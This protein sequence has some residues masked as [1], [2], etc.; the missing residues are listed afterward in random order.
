M[1]LPVV[2]GNDL[3]YAIVSFET[4]IIKPFLSGKTLAFFAFL[5]KTGSRENSEAGSCNH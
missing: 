3:Q 2:G 5:F 4:L 1:L